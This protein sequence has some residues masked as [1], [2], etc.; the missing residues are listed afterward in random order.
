MW[1]HFARFWT[2]FLHKKTSIFSL[3]G[4]FFIDFSSNFAPPKPSKSCSRLGAVH[5]FVKS[6]L[7]ENHQ[8]K[9][10]LETVF[11][12][13]KR[14]FLVVFDIIFGSLCIIFRHFFGV[15]FCIDFW[16]PFYHFSSFFSPTVP[17]S[18]IFGRPLAPSWSQNGA[19]W[20]PKSPKCRKNL[21]RGRKKLSTG[22]FWWDFGDICLPPRRDLV[23]RRLPQEP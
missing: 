17:K 14:R 1:I 6:P 11:D 3:R 5:I 2:P 21:V 18:V 15:D 13:K 19:K 9:S 8:K 4:Q 23:P 22:E 7:Q 12:T 16:M 20:H 10:I